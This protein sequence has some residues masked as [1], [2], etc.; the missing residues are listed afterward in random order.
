MKTASRILGLLFYVT[1]TVALT[2]FMVG[3]GG[4]FYS[5]FMATTWDKTQTSL[6]FLQPVWVFTLIA[7]LLSCGLVVAIKTRHK[8]F[9]ELAATKFSDNSRGRYA[10]PIVLVM[11]VL[12][13]STVGGAFCAGPP[14]TVRKNGDV[15]EMKTR[16]SPWKPATE[17]QAIGH[18]RNM[19]VFF[20]IMIMDFSWL[21]LITSLGM[22][23]FA[24]A[25]REESENDVNKAI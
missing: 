9:S 11:L 8:G 15:F 7:L 5:A 23:A 13:F 16:H 22:H 19:G 3:G 25:A 6:S 17:S 4:I 21:M 20:S 10:R 12:V 2:G 18:A 1:I 14:A 24:A